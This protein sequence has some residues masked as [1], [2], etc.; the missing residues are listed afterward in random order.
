[1]NGFNRNYLNEFKSEHKTVCRI[2]EDIKGFIQ[3]NNAQGIATHM[4]LIRQYLLA[5]LKKEDDKPYGDLLKEAKDKNIELVAI[6][7]NTF[8]TAMKGI[9]ART[10]K[11]FDKYHAEDEIIKHIAEFNK[12]FQGAYEDIQ[13][14]VDN[15]EKM[16]YPMYEKHCC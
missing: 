16:L 2:L 12:D 13:K 7:V 9:A 4:D 1:M 15:E 6:A 14:R 8:S 11:F 5:H 10:L 3:T